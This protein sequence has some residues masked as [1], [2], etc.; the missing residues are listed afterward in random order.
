MVAAR[1]ML[2]Q[3]PL[4]RAAEILAQT[5]F[6]RAAITKTMKQLMGFLLSI[7]LLFFL[8]YGRGTKTKKFAALY[9]V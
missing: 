1:E 2:P 3:N 4:L 5:P 8:Q 9:L 6:F 7:L